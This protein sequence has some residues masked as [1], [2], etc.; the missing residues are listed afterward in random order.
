[1]VSRIS[2]VGLPGGQ[3]VS[4]TGST[5]LRREGEAA[6][7]VMS[8][9]HRQPCDTTTRISK[10]S[11]EFHSGSKSFF[12][13]TT[14]WLKDGKSNGLIQWCYPSELSFGPPPGS[15]FMLRVWSSLFEHCCSNNVEGGSE[16]L[17]VFG[18][19]CYKLHNN[20]NNHGGGH[21]LA[22]HKTVSVGTS[23]TKKNSVASI[24]LR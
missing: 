12:L 16:V 20:N 5:L 13:S 1:V 22:S 14:S 2:V 17:C 6:L 23:V 9:P 8:Y 21:E 18:N 11:I 15:N 3:P 7:G 24:A 10:A 19:L 4:C